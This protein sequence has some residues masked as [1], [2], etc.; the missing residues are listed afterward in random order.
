MIDALHVS[1]ADRL[2]VFLGGKCSLRILLV[3]YQDYVRYREVADVVSSPYQV[4]VVCLHAVG[5]IY[6]R[7]VDHDGNRLVALLRRLVVAKVGKLHAA[8]GLCDLCARHGERQADGVPFA[9]LDGPQYPYVQRNSTGHRTIF[10]VLVKDYF[11]FHNLL[12]LLPVICC[13]V[14]RLA[15]YGHIEG[16]IGAIT[17]GSRYNRRWRFIF[18]FDIG[19]VGAVIEY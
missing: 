11:I 2:S 16:G 19:Q 14:G 6:R 15:A 1:L 9:A 5:C 12:E 10:R 3:G 4:G 18:Y 13:L 7:E 17:E 8:Q